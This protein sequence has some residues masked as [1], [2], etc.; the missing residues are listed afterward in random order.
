MLELLKETDFSD[1][2]DAFGVIRFPVDLD[3]VLLN[4]IPNV[5]K[6]FS[7]VRARPSGIG[8]ERGSQV[9][10]SYDGGS[11]TDLL[12]NIKTGTHEQRDTYS[13]IQRRFREFFP[14]WTFEAVG[15]QGRAPE[16][17]FNRDGHNI[18]INQEAVGTGVVEV[19]TLIANLEGKTD[20]VLVLEE[21][22]L[23]LHPQSQRALQHMIVESSERNQIFVL[24]HS[25]YFIDANYLPGLSRMWMPGDSARLTSFPKNL[26][27]K[28]LATLRESF[29]ELRQREVLSSRATLLVEGQTEEAFLQAIGPRMGLDT[30][31]YGVTILSVKG[32]GGYIPY[33]RL[34]ESM[35]IPYLCHRDQQKGTPRK[36]KAKFRI[37][38]AE[39]EEYFDQQGLGEI[40]REAEAAV[41]PGN[42]VKIGRHLGIH[43]DPDKVPE[44]FKE[45]LQEIISI[46]NREREQ[47]EG[48]Q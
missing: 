29:R 13:L 17:V 6:S 43:M 23:H 41:E 26:K 12:M 28:E 31:A 18:D 34:L 40:Y 27:T 9:L 42:K 47:M 15:Q 14:G 2:D 30:D 7:D 4:L 45:L 16:I 36:Y 25:P 38:G 5:Y 46:A 35:E 22:E 8:G 37:I 39:F 44:K 21:P 11:T 33:I 3:G 24:T 1:L 19:L 32:E 20:S 48:E 10:E